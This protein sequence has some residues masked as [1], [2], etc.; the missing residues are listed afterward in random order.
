[1]G[2]LAKSLLTLSMEEEMVDHCL[3]QFEMVGILLEFLFKFFSVARVLPEFVRDAR[4][5]LRGSFNCMDSSKAFKLA[6]LFLFWTTWQV[7]NKM[8]LPFIG[9]SMFFFPISRSGFGIL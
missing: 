5:R 6:P 2:C 3:L 9:Y 1:M 4:P 8:N 7:W